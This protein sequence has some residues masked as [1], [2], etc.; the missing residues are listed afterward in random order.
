M[1]S[2]EDLIKLAKEQG[3]LTREQIVAS[4]SPEITDQDQVKDI[5]SMVSDMGINILESHPSK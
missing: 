1:S 4:L 3:Y 2:A 5:E